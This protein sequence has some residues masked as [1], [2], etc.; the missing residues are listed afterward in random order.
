VQL[1]RSI[2]CCFLRAKAK[3]KQYETVDVETQA[4]L[5]LDH[6]VT[7][8]TKESKEPS[9]FQPLCIEHADIM[10][11]DILRLL[12]YEPYIPRSVLVDYLKTLMAFHLALYHLK[13]LQ[14]L[15]KLV[16]QRSGNALD[17]SLSPFTIIVDM[18]DI[19]NPHMAEL[20]RKSADRTYRQIPAF[21]QANFVVKKLDEMAEYLS[22]KTGKLATPGNGVF[23]VVD[24]VTLLK[25]EHDIER[26]AYFKFRLASL[27]E[28]S[29][30]ESEDIDPEIRDVTGMGL[31][32]FESFIEILMAY[33][34]K[35]HHQ[36]I[37]QC[38]DC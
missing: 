15:P 31:G 27:I 36:Y 7:Q 29:T 18:A 26:Q 14:I 5:R 16:K 38:L 32:E 33:R 22:K 34:G 13:L 30:S 3:A 35:Y 1:N 37:T 2:P 10:A 23:N 20:A 8:D 24:L 28:E 17:S 9:R 25:P 12:A 4:I 6:Q 21:V 11:E 19:N